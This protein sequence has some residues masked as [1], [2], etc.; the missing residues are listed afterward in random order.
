MR[1]HVR[2]VAKCI[3]VEI[4]VESSAR[5]VKVDVKVPEFRKD[6]FI[7]WLGYVV[8]KSESGYGYESFL[9]DLD[10]DWEEIAVEIETRADH[11]EQVMRNYEKNIRKGRKVIFAVP[12]ERVAEK[13]SKILWDGDYT[14]FV[15]TL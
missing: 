13:V 7:D 4:N 1:Y 2:K 9:V 10:S 12:D 5:D 8:P 14:V 3:E 11:P 15:L 6:S